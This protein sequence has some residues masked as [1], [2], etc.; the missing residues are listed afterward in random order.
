MCTV[1][2]YSEHWQEIIKRRIDNKLDRE[3]SSC[4]LRVK[5]GSEELGPGEVEVRQP[6]RVEGKW[7]EAVDAKEVI[8]RT[9]NK[10]TAPR[11]ALP[12]RQPEL[13]GRG[14]SQMRTARQRV[15]VHNMVGL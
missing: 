7:Q 4:S 8:M 15:W 12:V 10:S 3:H 6:F 13:S 11:S 14:M 2:C 9:L 5:A 1:H